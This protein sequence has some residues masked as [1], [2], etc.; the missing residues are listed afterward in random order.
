MGLGSAR[1]GAGE[2]NVP[3]ALTSLV[4]RAREL[5]SIE[6]SLRRDRLVTITGPGGV[7]KTRLALELARRRIGKPADGIWLAD[8][9][10]IAESQDVATEVA[11]TLEVLGSRN[12]TARDVLRRYLADR[13]VLLVLDNC[14]HVLSD[15]AEL[16][17]SLLT[18]CRGVRIL[19]TSREPLGVPGE[20]IWRLDPLAPED[21][22]RLFMERARRREP[23]F[24]P[25]QAADAV[26]AELCER[27]D[28]LPLAIE[29]AAARMNVMS[30]AEVFAGLDRRVVSL[31]A[32]SPLTPPRQRTVRATAEW[33]YH[34]LDL[35]EQRC[36]RS[37][38]V[39]VGG[40]DAAAA[41]A[42]VADFSFDL[43]ARLV[44][45]SLVAVVGGP[46]VGTR[47]RL[48]ETMREYGHELLVAAGELDEARRRHLR[49][50][51]AR[52][53]KPETS[54]PSTG[55]QALLDELAADYENVRAA[56]E[57]AAE[58]DPCGAR[59]FLIAVNDLFVFFGQADGSRFA[60]LLL[61]RCAARDR[62]RAEVL[63]MAGSLAIMTADAQL[64]RQALGEAQ[65]LS[66]SLDAT[67]LEGWARFFLGL[68]ETLQARVGAARPHLLA[69]CEL[70]SR[71]GKR[72]GW[73][74]ATAALGLTFLVEGDP[75]HARELAEQA[76][77]VDVEEGDLWAQGQCH[78]YLG[79][80][81]DDAS[82]GADVSGFHY[83]RAIECLRPFRGGPLL[84]VAM[85]GLAGL[86]VER[87]AA[88]ALRVAAAA[89]K[90][91]TRA[92][93][94]FPPVF[95]ERAERV[96]AAAEAALGSEAPHAW[97]S[98]RRLGVDDAIALAL[99]A[100]D[101]RQPPALGLSAR[102]LAVVRQVAE[103]LTNKEIATRLHLSVRTVESH[104]RNALAKVG[105]ENRTQLAIWARDRIQ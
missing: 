80:I 32:G 100:K 71:V 10:A 29:L 61:E 34:L 79:M 70:H 98:G 105:L 65:Q 58:T 36:F 1:V 54:W 45:K 90:L 17:S 59:R 96:R 101:T 72:T 78:L 24:E 37:L 60:G 63:I 94:E 89:Y 42:V 50:F 19:A 83:Q 31:D 47:Y 57:T 91:R 104:V 26:I 40:F 33:S 93:G 69:A 3:F 18:T 53:G 43:L 64:A 25:D 5:E 22:R 68:A 74:R 23:R 49:H 51:A 48:L 7:G 30:P 99:G 11:R 14:E 13:E 6:G 20:A 77:S 9:T 2:H 81:A 8:L 87:D 88:Q 102:E 67:E 75:A 62:A 4:G 52:A 38:A 76:L 44:D 16:S 97:A 46:S 86:L 66:A 39:F 15:A 27:L 21:A 73:A 56:L 55:A 103:G 84:P 82:T 95:R 35:A 92:G 41:G 12:T 28:R 85:I